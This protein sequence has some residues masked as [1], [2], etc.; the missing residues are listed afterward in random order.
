MGWQGKYFLKGVT[1]VLSLLRFS[2]S[3]EMRL[4]GSSLGAEG[5]LLGEERLALDLLFL[6][7]VFIAQ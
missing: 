6:E 4:G 5:Y 7:V 2:A 3:I 1:R